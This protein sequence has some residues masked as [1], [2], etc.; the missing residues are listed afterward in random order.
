MFKESKEH[1]KETGWSYWQHLRHSV[2][3]SNRLIA[4]AIKSYIHGIFPCWYKSDGPI[5]II[6][7]YHTIMKIH[8]IWKINKDMKDRGDV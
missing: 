7:M 5:T 4:T 1:L 6:K 3:Q 2:K 8:H